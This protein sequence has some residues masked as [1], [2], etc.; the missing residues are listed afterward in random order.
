[1]NVRVYMHVYR[2]VSACVCVYCVY[3]CVYIYIYMCVCVCVC[4]CSHTRHFDVFA[5]SLHHPPLLP[6]IKRDRICSPEKGIKRKLYTCVVCVCVCVR[7][8][9]RERRVR[10]FE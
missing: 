6:H 10:K 3:V 2:C 1:M 4:V 5:V 8:R 7:E 9:E